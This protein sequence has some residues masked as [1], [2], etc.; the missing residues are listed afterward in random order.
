MLYPTV[1]T[2]ERHIADDN[3]LSHLSR[4]GL[5][6]PNVVLSSFLC[7]SFRILDL[8]NPILQKY[9]Q[10]APIKSIAMETLQS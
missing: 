2:A 9:S 5:I 10:E 7:H 6:F 8:Y 1:T 3:Y 4:G